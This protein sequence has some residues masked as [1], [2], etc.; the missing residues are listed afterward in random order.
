MAINKLKFISKVY[1]SFIKVRLLEREETEEVDKFQNLSLLFLLN[2]KSKCNTHVWK[3]MG[4][5][6]NWD[7][8]K[9]ISNSKFV[10]TDDKNQQISI[11]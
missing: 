1:S 10:S 5:I 3:G 4:G 8:D 9:N 2:K 6:K 7:T 11:N